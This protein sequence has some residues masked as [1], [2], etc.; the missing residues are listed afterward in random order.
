MT[1]VFPDFDD[2]P[3]VPGTPQGCF[4]GFYDKDGVKDEIGCK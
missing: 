1:Y 4:W 2:L 3:A